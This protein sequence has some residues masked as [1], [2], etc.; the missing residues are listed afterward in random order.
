[1]TSSHSLGW[2]TYG[3]AGIFCG[4]KLSQ[5]T[6][7]QIFAIKTFANCGETAIM[8]GQETTN[9]IE[10]V[11]TRWVSWK[12]TKWRP[13]IEATMSTWQFGMPPLDK[14]CLASERE[15]ISM[16]PTLSLSLRI[17]TRPLIMTPPYSMKIS[18]VKTL[19][20]CPETAEFAKVFTRERFPLHGIYTLCIF[21][22]LYSRMSGNDDEHSD[23]NVHS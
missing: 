4:W 9:E 15:A 8:H 1:M 14:Y 19:A 7:S 5:T 22:S 6:E 12:T 10:L 16:I 23:P 17:M 18:M 21:A 20:N 13:L 2:N 3:I 11:R